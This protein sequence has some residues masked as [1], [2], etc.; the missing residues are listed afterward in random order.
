MDARRRCLAV[1][2]SWTAG[3][4]GSLQMLLG[5]GCLPIMNINTPRG[6]AACFRSAHGQDQPG[7]KHSYDMAS[8]RPR[9]PISSYERPAARV[10][11]YCSRFGA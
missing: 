7:T 9:G 1:G 4:K 5:L 11:Q 3:S 10:S 8:K 6:S 2:S